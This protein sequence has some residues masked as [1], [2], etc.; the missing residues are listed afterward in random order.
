[1]SMFFCLQ[2]CCEMPWDMPSDT[3]E[4]RVWVDIFF[5]DQSAVD[6]VREL[7]AAEA[8]YRESKYH[9]VLATA[10]VVR[11]A[12][13]LLEL[14]VRMEAGKGS[15]MIGIY[16]DE[17][18]DSVEGEIELLDYEE[19][20]SRDLFSTMEA[21]SDDDKDKI[22]ARIHAVCTPDVFNS[23]IRHVAMVFSLSTKPWWFYLILAPVM[24]PAA[25]IL[26][27]I[28]IVLFLIVLVPWIVL[29]AVKA[30]VICCLCLGRAVCPP[31]P[32]GPSYKRL[33]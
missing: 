1:M 12:W 25:L 5:N 30:V 27:L 28:F 15:G 23:R 6:I 8:I 18:L 2:F 9:L 33:L 13:C 31:Q 4:L 21:F 32:A 22:K 19:T 3:A 10:G 14:L 17:Q 7:D 26:A 16:G 11:R 29:M 20:K 24:S